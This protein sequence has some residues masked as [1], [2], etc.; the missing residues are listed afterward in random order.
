MPK[1]PLEMTT[2]TGTLRDL[3]AADIERFDKESVK[4][5]GIHRRADMALIAFAAATTIVAGL[6]LVLPGREREIQFAVIAL[7]AVATGVAAWAQSR[8]ARDLWKHERE[9]YYALK[10]LLRELDFRASVGALEMDG[11]EDIFRRSSAVLGSSTAKWSGILAK[12]IEQPS[13]D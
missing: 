10:D 9:V 11:I 7:S 12:K 8:R 3:L 2:A 4:H 6:G 13:R 1:T 5:K